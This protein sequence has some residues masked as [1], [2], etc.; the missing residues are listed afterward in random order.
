MTASRALADLA[1]IRSTYGAPGAR[2]RLDLL[3]VLEHADLRAA[4]QIIQLHELLCFLHA[5]P[6]DGAV[7]EQVSRMLKGFSQRPD[8]QRH[9]RRLENTGIAG[10]DTVYPFGFSTAKWLAA[11]CA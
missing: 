11:R 4:P 7:F 2:I 1:A 5:Y 8:V 3:R 10:T 6:D 9:R